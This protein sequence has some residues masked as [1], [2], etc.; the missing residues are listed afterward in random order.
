MEDLPL[1]EWP[2]KH[3]SLEEVRITDVIINLLESESQKRLNSSNC[4]YLISPHPAHN[5]DALTS[6]LTDI[7]TSIQINDKWQTLHFGY[8]NRGWALVFS[9]TSSL[10]LLL[11]ILFPH[12][13]EN[14]II[15]VIEKKNNIQRSDIALSD[16]AKEIVLGNVENKFS[17]HNYVGLLFDCDRLTKIFE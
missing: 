12:G 6:K 1:I 10:N 14:L 3:D 16:L 9:K 8:K 13:A 17:Q 5:I 4:F 2:E 15:A 11:P 7:E